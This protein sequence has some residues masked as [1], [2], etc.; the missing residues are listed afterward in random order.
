MTSQ[1]ETG[2]LGRIL[3]VIKTHF[4]W[5]TQNTDSSLKLLLA[6]NVGKFIWSCAE[7]L[8]A[9]I[10]WHSS[11]EITNRW[12]FTGSLIQ[13]QIW[14][15]SLF[16]A[17]CCRW[18]LW[19]IKLHWNLTISNRTGCS[20]AGSTNQ[21]QGFRTG[22]CRPMGDFAHLYIQSMCATKISL[23]NQ[24]RKCTYNRCFFP[25]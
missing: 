9:R 3:S 20:G 21:P 18:V 5:D 13:Q 2:R 10:D 23:M 11:C 4:L 19:P 7:T 6:S 1:L 24:M 12:W 14:L 22:T 8:W 16:S 17:K 15:V 25:S